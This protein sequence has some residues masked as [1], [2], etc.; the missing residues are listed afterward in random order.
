[1]PYKARSTRSDHLE[2]KSD[3]HRGEHPFG[4]AGQLISLG[5][6]LVVW[7]GDSFF[8]RRTTFLADLV[9][10]AVRL[11]LLT[12]ALGTSIYLV[13]SGHVVISHHERPKTVVTTGA[14]RYVRHPIYL[15]TLL[16][17]L[18]LSMA[19]ASLLSLAVTVPIF[20]FYNHI[21][22]YE[23][24]LLQARFGDEYQRYRS[25]TGKWAPRL[26]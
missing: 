1:M 14:F 24:R 23:E 5:V 21:A 10:L 25:G 16:C 9:P 19:T 17:Y 8:L 6:F 13:K 26:A 11:L 3:D 4:H 2:D 18:G 22:S 20:V 7:G 15:G 12:L